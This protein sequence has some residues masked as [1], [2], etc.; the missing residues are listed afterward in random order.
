[1]RL[2]RAIFTLAKL[3]NIIPKDKLPVFDVMETSTLG[4]AVG[5]MIATRAHRVW[6]VDR[7][8]GPPISVVT[9]TDVF[10]VITPADKPEHS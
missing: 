2:D 8:Q 5:K 3:F 10:G 1:M 6:V 7:V 4:Y 9:L